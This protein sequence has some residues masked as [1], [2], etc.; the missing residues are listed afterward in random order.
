MLNIFR[1][2]AQNGFTLV[3]IMIVIAIIAILAAIAIPQF[4]KYRL[5]GYNKSA[6]ADIKQMYTA[7][8]AFFSESHGGSVDMAVLKAY[9]YNQTNNVT[10]TASGTVGSLVIR[11]S[12]TLGTSAYSLDSR[13]IIQAY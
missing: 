6:N 13:G 12:H 7:S 3:E 5:D 9:G 2:K 11:A 4:I 8:Q 10:V 1:K